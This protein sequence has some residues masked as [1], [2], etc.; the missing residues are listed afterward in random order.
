MK[1]QEM[2]PERLREDKGRKLGKAMRRRIKKQVHELHDQV[3]L[4]RLIDPSFEG[5]LKKWDA[6]PFLNNLDRYLE[7]QARERSS[8]LAL[9]RAA[10]HDNTGR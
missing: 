4:L 8:A 5:E 3:R 10:V 7:G 2:T 1:R 9:P 6:L